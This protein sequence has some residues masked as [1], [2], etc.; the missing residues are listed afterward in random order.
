MNGYQNFVEIFRS[1]QFIRSGAIA[2]R[3]PLQ[4]AVAS[5][6]VIPAFFRGICYIPTVRE[7]K[8]HFIENKQD[9]FTSLF[10]FRYGRRRWYWGLSS[11]ARRYG[12][13][14]S[15]TKVLEIVALER[16]RTIRVAERIR[17]LEQKKSYRSS[18]LSEYLSSLDISTIFIHKGREES[19]SSI[20]I[21][22][23]MGPVCTKEQ[24]KE[25]IGRFSSRVRDRNLKDIYRRIIQ[26]LDANE[27]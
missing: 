3:Y 6:Y 26:N 25:D 5:L 22:D 4:K 15:A 7:R 10:D 8:G 16:P 21:D 11:A 23:V 24:I 27:R 13:E 2:K 17:S 14:W 18:V 1:G 12:I 19:L 9:F 20:R